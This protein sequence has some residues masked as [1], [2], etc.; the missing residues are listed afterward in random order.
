MLNDKVLRFLSIAAIGLLILS[1]VLVYSLWQI[2]TVNSK[3]ILNN[4]IRIC[5]FNT[6]EL[7]KIDSN[8]LLDNFLNK[9]SSVGKT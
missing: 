1:N 9:Q 6:P 4:A 3:T 8:E 5:D 7:I 2:E